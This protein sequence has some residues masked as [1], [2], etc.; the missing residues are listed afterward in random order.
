MSP[1]DDIRSHTSFRGGFEQES[2][3]TISTRSP[4]TSAISYS[5][6][7][8]ISRTSSA[9]PTAK[10]THNRR[11]SSLALRL[12]PPPS[13]P[14]PVFARSVSESSLDGDGVVNGTSRASEDE[15]EGAE[16]AEAKSNRKMA[17]LEITNRSL[18]A[19]NST[20]EATRHRQAK[21]IRELRRKLRESRL[22]LPPSTYQQLKSE[23][24]EE[25]DEEEVSEDDSDIVKGN[26][27]GNE[28]YQRVRLLL[29]N[30]IE[31]GKRALESTPSDFGTGAGTKVTVLSAEEV[32][33]WNDSDDHPRAISP[34]R[35]AIPESN[36]SEDEDEDNNDHDL[37]PPIR[38]TTPI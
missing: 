32:E 19:I 2:D 27:P 17:D 16:R 5:S 10:L 31:T 33:N 28:G 1:D 3:P 7:S 25:E 38:I 13:P 26:G 30:L 4:P 9:N 15:T 23:E 12:E 20:L 34:S 36:G 6:H 21:E 11:R 35:V 14:S 24:E 18:T 37:I 22:I 8:S 29:E